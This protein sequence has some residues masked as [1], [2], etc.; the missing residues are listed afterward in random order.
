[1]G[2]VEGGTDGE[3]R[4]ELVGTAE[5]VGAGKGGCRGGGRYM[6]FFFKLME[7]CGCRM[8]GGEVGD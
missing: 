2:Q 4:V 3:G 5:L 1:M 6:Y 8:S 7:E